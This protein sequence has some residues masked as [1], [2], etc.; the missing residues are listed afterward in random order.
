MSGVDKTIHK[1]RADSQSGMSPANKLVRKFGN[2]SESGSPSRQHTAR[3]GSLDA[4]DKTPCF[5]NQDRRGSVDYV[6]G[7]ISGF[8]RRRRRSSVDI[9]KQKLLFDE[10]AKRKSVQTVRERRHSM[11][12]QHDVTNRLSQ[13]L[14]GMSLEDLNFQRLLN[15]FPW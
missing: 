13:G 15:K 2:Y 9:E 14:S 8:D 3:R 7:L 6:N 11:Q 1:S 5:K 12:L 10:L 4:G